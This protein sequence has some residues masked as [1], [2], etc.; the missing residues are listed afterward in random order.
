MGQG[1]SMERVND[2]P[3]I[4]LKLC[5]DPSVK[6]WYFPSSLVLRE[7]PEAQ[8]ASGNFSSQGQAQGTIWHLL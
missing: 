7:S 8:G 6:T 5:R 3:A 2:I 4:V 1:N